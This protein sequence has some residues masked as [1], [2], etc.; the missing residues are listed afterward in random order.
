[1]MKMEDGLKN[2]ENA[3]QLVQKELA[4][5]KDELRNFKTASGSTVGSE[6]STG[7]GMGLDSGTFARPL[8]SSFAME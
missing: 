6:A 2:E 8:P 5:M 4:V 3:I 1:M 7:V